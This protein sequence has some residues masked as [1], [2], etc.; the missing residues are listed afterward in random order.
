MAWSVRGKI[1]K[2]DRHDARLAM[3]HVIPVAKTIERARRA[4]REGKSPKTQAGKFAREE[5]RHVR[6]GKHGA[7][8]PQQAIA[9][10]LS[11]ARR[12][13]VEVGGHDPSRKQPRSGSER[14]N[15]SLRE[16]VL[17]P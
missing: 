6:E 12:G 11:K 14:P 16:K 5:I 10:G 4:K 2:S 9:I 17:R 8:F 3:E 13:G 1:W 7:R 15:A